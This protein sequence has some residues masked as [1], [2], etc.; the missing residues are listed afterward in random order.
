M[1]VQ[2]ASG[3]KPG[4]FSSAIMAYHEHVNAGQIVYHKKT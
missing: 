3:T 1:V 2:D 4:S